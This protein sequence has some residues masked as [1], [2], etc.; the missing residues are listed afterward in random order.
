MHPPPYIQCIF[1]FFKYNFM[2]IDKTHIT[3]TKFKTKKQKT[4]TYT[5]HLFLS[6][7]MDDNEF[8][9]RGKLKPRIKLNHSR[10]THA[11]VNTV[12]S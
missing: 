6:L 4:K 12:S 2:L 10:H 9:Q 1:L 7:L 11:L 8:K 3:D 5:M